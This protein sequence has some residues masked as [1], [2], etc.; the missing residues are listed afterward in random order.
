MNSASSDTGNYWGGNRRPGHRGGTGQRHWFR[1]T[2][3]PG[4]KR[5]QLGM[6]AFGDPRCVPHPRPEALRRFMAILRRLLGRRMAAPVN[7][8][9]RR[10]C[11][12]TPQTE[13]PTNP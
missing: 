4:W 9:K 8:L 11:R 6:P 2:G 5:A 10:T 7:R 3:L 12:T 13:N 1:I